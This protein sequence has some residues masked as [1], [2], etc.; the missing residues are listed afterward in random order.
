MLAARPLQGDTSRMAKTLYIHIG[1]YKTGTTALQVFLAHNR[2]FLL[3]NGVDYLREGLDHAKHSRAAFCLLRA[4]QV[5]TLMHG[6]RDPTPPEAVWQRLLDAVRASRA[7]AA[8][9]SSEE[10]MRLGAHP[11]AAARLEAVIAQ[12]RAA[13]DLRFRI[14]AWLRAPDDHLRSWY[15]QLVKMGVRVPGYDAALCHVVEPVHV[16]YGLALA[17]WI[18]IFGADAV[19]LRPYD[20]ASRHD[21]GLLRDFLDVLGIALPDRGVTL[22]EADPNPRLD[23]RIVELVRILQN[24]GV[25]RDMARWIRKRAEAY[26]ETEAQAAPPA[27]AAAFARMRAQAAAG[28]DTLAGQLAG[29]PGNGVDLARL[30]AQLPA[31]QDPAQ[32]AAWQLTGLALNEVQQLRRRMHEQNTELRARLQALEAAAGITPPASPA[33]NRN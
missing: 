17:P 20:P 21:N 18:R 4:A 30:R 2:R 31:P 5:G 14:L 32:A 11:A 1:H 24:L 3:R 7:P 6:Y 22:P 12:A 15:N 19:T 9:I 23:D 26:L 33:P 16:D 29:Q 10:F 8:L 28:L 27:D 25:D 13:G